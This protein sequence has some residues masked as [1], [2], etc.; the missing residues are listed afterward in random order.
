MEVTEIATAKPLTE[1]ELTEWEA[2]AH[3]SGTWSGTEVLR[4]IGEVRSLRGNWDPLACITRDLERCSGDPTIADTR[5]SVHHIVA[6]APQYGWD[7]ERLREH[8]F[9][10]L[11]LPQIHAAIAYYLAHREEIDD[12]LRREREM[13]EH[14]PLAPAG[15]QR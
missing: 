4:L 11:T 3:E 7:L 1:A 12:L 13:K 6:L 9:P 8:E 10:D 2:R 14:L 5:I 15:K